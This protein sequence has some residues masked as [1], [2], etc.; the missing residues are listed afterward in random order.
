[1]LHMFHLSIPKT[2]APPPEVWAKALMCSFNLTLSSD[3][4][5]LK[6]K[7]FCSVCFQIEKYFLNGLLNKNVSINKQNS[8]QSK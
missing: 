6:S 1:M 3:I 2:K 7:S 8:K 4:S 5:P